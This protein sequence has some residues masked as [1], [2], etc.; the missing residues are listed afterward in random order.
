M[1]KNV[2]AK[3]ESLSKFI[4]DV[5]ADIDELFDISAEQCSDGSQCPAGT[6]CCKMPNDKFGCCPYPKATCCS[7][8]VHCCPSGYKCDLSQGHCVMKM[9]LS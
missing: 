1:M 4:D 7:D 5:M 6:T 8:G 9:V 3:K 2:S